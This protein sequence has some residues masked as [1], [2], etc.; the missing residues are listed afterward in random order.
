MTLPTVDLRRRCTGPPTPR[1]RAG[2][3]AGGRRPPPPTARSGRERGPEARPLSAG[4]GVVRVREPSNEITVSLPAGAS[5]RAGTSRPPSP[6]ALASPRLAQATAA[7][8]WAPAPWPTRTMRFSSTHRTVTGSRRRVPREPDVV[9]IAGAPGTFHCGSASGHRADDDGGCVLGKPVEAGLG[10]MGFEALTH[11]CE[12]DDERPWCRRLGWGGGVPPVL[13]VGIL[14]R[15]R[16][17]LGFDGVGA[18]GGVTSGRSARFVHGD[19]GADVRN[20]D[21]R[22]RWSP[23]YGSWTT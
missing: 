5:R 8:I 11:V 15:D 21:P 18:V 1:A 4:D 10:E 6:S 17:E 14:E 16:R 3:A 12:A 22:D 2:S 9:G 7:A 23:G 19:P 13:A 20:P